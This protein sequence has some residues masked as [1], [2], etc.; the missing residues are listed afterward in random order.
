[1]LNS[2]VSRSRRGI[3]DRKAQVADLQRQVRWLQQIE[4]LAT[5]VGTAYEE[6]HPAAALMRLRGSDELLAKLRELDADVVNGL[7]AFERQLVGAVEEV[8]ANLPRSLPDALAQ[9]NVVLDRSSRHPSYSC[10]DGF[11][12]V[13]IDPRAL[14]ARVRTRGMKKQKIPLDPDLLA[15]RVA[16]ELSRCFDRPVDNARFAAEVRA[17]YGRALGDHPPGSALPVFDVVKALKERQPSLSLDEFL[18]DLARLVQSG[19]DAA[20][21]VARLRLDHTKRDREGVLLPGLESR[22]YFGYIRFGSGGDL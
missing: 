9:H 13:E 8:I 1:M 4:G 19:D 14:E 11:L 7:E 20:D 5:D 22:G 15:A 17:A 16:E 6:G 12:T 21:D 18:V 3:E 10:A 2:I